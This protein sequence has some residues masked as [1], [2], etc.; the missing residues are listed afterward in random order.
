MRQVVVNTQAKC[1]GWIGS[2]IGKKQLIA[3]TGLGLSF[4]VLTH[5]LGNF[6]LVLS[7]RAYNEYS[8]ALIS[9]PLIELAEAG[10]LL[11]FLGHMVLA[12]RISMRNMKARDVG[13]A[14]LPSGEKGTSWAKRS[15]WAQGL[16]ILVFTILHL[17]TFKYGTH[18]TVDYGKGEI[19]D[20]HKL[21][22]EVFQQPGYVVWYLIALVVLLVHLSHGVA[23][24]LQTLGIHHPRF[25]KCIK[26]LSWFY[27]V[28]V[29]VGF[30]VQPIYVFF[31]YKG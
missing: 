9:N 6:L 13:Y 7:A 27:A 19:R 28:F 16:L 11:M 14:V 12:S 20:L 23:S 8:H 4:F 26:G 24:S 2:T 18:Y 29:G 15:L 3:V 1:C 30:I 21:V 17:I 10:L 22:V 5:M 25:Q 31:I